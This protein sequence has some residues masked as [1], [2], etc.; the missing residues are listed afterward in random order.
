[1]SRSW[2][3]LTNSASTV[4][5]LKTPVALMSKLMS[6]L[7]IDIPRAPPTPGHRT[8]LVTQDYEYMPLGAAQLGNLILDL[9]LTSRSHAS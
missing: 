7:K 6:L 2:D 4:I 3:V 1:M 5:T 9:Y 8:Q